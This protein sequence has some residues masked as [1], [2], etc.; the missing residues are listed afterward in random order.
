MQFQNQEEYRQFC[1]KKELRKTANGLGIMLLV[2]FALEI[3]LAAIIP[4]I[5]KAAGVSS[6][7]G[8][9]S[10]FTLLENGLLSSLLFFTVAYVYVLIK[11][12]RFSVLFPFEKIGAKRLTMLVV[13]GSA[14]SLMSNIAPDLLTEV[15]GLFGVTNSGGSIT[16]VNSAPSVL[17]Y[18]LV[19]AVMPAFTEEFA[20]RGVIMG[21]LRKYSDSL[22]LVVSAA[23]FA[24]THGNFVQIPFTFCCGLMFGF[25]V[26]KTNSLLPSIIVHFINNG[27]SVAFDLLYQYEVLSTGMVNLLYGAIFVILGLL[28]LVFIRKIAAEDEDFFTLPRADDVM[29]YRSK[30]KAVASSPTLISYSVIMLLFA[31]YVILQPYLIQWGVIKY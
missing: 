14:V 29:P 15:F 9:S 25:L 1:Y 3:A 20:F 30:L 12:R 22:A 23:L 11:R 4:E 28:A 27:L 10:D 26:L 18:F 21:S 8:T 17:M 13:I 7:L 6:I 5:L 2:I 24:L 16:F 31:V 19:V